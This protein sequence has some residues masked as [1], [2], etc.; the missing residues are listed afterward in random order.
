MYE[1]RYAVQ[2][3]VGELGSNA[4]GY[5]GLRR[6]PTCGLGPLGAQASGRN[7]SGHDGGAPTLD[8][9]YAAFDKHIV[10][11]MDDLQSAPGDPIR[12]VINTIG[13]RRGDFGAND[14]DQSKID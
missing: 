2:A 11:V 9:V 13:R 8:A 4:M 12:P 6:C 1:A 14:V 5:F 7:G 10:P 3:H